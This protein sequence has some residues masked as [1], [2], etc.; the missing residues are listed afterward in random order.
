MIN[1]RLLRIIALPLV[2]VVG[3]VIYFTLF[4]NHGTVSIALDPNSPVKTNARAWS[5]SN[6]YKKSY[7][8]PA[9]LRLKAGSYVIT[10]TGQDSAEFQQTVVVRANQTTQVTVVLEQNPADNLIGTS[11]ASPKVPYYSLFPYNGG[12]YQLSA[13]LN[14][15][16]TAITSITIVVW[17][18]IPVSQTSLFNQERD[19]IVASAKK[20][21]ADQGVPSSITTTVIDQ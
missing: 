21:L 8:L 12:E 13:T 5:S 1:F 18:Q 2:L 16:Q 7:L 10:A 4:F 15:E 11:D 6:H 19:L 17:H 9:T 14:N 3:G 20:W